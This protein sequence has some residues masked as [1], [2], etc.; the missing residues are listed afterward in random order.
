MSHIENNSAHT[1][2]QSS[3][4]GAF[5]HVARIGRNGAIL[6]GCERCEATRQMLHGV[7]S[8]YE[9]V[10]KKD[11]NVLQQLIS[12]AFASPEK[13]P[14]GVLRFVGADNTS[15]WLEVVVSA[16]FCGDEAVIMANDVTDCVRLKSFSEI[17]E[18]TVLI[19]N[20]ELEFTGARAIYLSPNVKRIFE[21]PE[22]KNL[23]TL[24]ELLDFFPSDQKAQ[25]LAA[26]EKLFLS[27]TSFD[28]TLKVNGWRNSE[29]FVQ[30][31]A[32]AQNVDG[33][34]NRIFGTCRDVT[35]RVLKER[36]LSKEKEKAE[37]ASRTKSQFLAN[38][39]HEIRT[40]LNGVIGVASLLEAT[41]LNDEQR[42]FLALIRESGDLLLSVLN[43][44][45]DLS[46]VEAGHMELEAEPF[47]V[48]ALIPRL[49]GLY[50]MKAKEKGIYLYV[51]V[52]CNEMIERV[53][54]ANRI[55]QVLH[56]ILSNA[57]KF[58]EKG[59]VI[60]RVRDFENEPL[61][62]SIADTG[63]GMTE[64]Q[65]SRLF[66][67]F[68]QA[69]YS[70]T[71]KYGGTGLGMAIAKKM[72]EAMQGDVAVK[73]REGHGTEVSLN[74]PL[75]TVTAAK[76]QAAAPSSNL[77]SFQGRRALVAEDNRANQVVISAMLRKLGVEA[78]IADN[79][80]Q[81]VEA[82][83]NGGYDIYILDYSMPI[84]N[85]VEALQAI[86]EFELSRNR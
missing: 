26:S 85:G 73:S 21:I 23:S 9:T 69:D 83:K 60:L 16:P 51:D 61:H 45:L 25:L 5:D 80:Q 66:E 50:E 78:D 70:T 55:L 13:L 41:D 74:I 49:K 71:R 84:M 47:K 33:A 4:K 43:D 37:A 58:T 46:K 79:G 24:N 34:V 44:I 75:P 35:E 68:M 76:V 86:R 65:R 81:A 3:L 59:R 67:P 64:E 56:N 38:M 10:N 15:S 36:A 32:D 20:W 27:G 57:V 40:P 8:V 30:I 48:S 53:G 7:S 54:D 62:I 2:L 18:N 82:C 17:V 52:R 11:K 63:I 14:R 19:G 28:L 31:Y 6:S 77:A 39:S 72:V 12:E 29:K 1:V 42:K 22:G